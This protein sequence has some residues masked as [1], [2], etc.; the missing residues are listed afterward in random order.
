MRI[1]CKIDVKEIQQVI[2]DIRK[3]IED[4]RSLMVEL[5]D[6]LVEDIKNNIVRRKTAPDGTPWAPWMPSTAKARARK[7]NAAL[8]LL[9]DTGNLLR[10]ITSSVSGHNS[11]TVGTNVPYATYLQNGTPKM[12][13]RPFLGI[14]DRARSSINEAIY[15]YLGA[16]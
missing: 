9:Y 14:S 1:D 3:K 6:I 5:G 15:N 11:L 4:P 8:G 12:V 16:K 13:K 10:S 2:G 7:G